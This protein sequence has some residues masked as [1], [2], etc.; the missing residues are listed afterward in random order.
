MKKPD[1]GISHRRRNYGDFVH[2]HR[3]LNISATEN[4]YFIIII[5]S[6]IHEAEKSE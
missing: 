5:C 1:F 3:Y 2:I 6:Q 4:D